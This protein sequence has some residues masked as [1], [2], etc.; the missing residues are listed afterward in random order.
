MPDKRLRGSNAYSTHKS[1]VANRR[2]LANMDPVKRA[3]LRD[4]IVE[5]QA[6][7]QLISRVSRKQDYLRATKAAQ[8]SMLVSSAR[9][10]LERWY[11]LACCD[12]RT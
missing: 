9:A 3:A 11:V 12:G 1:T 2:R 7:W 4:R 5:Y 6:I 8:R 10:L